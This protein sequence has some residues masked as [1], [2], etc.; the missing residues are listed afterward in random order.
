MPVLE[1]V[2]L[3]VLEGGKLCVYIYIYSTPYM[4]V[5][6]VYNNSIYIY[7]QCTVYMEPI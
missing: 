6:Y 3:S 4:F 2:S 1:G 7:I 5:V